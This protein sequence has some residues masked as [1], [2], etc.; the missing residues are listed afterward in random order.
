MTFG[1]IEAGGTKFVCATGSGPNDLKRVTRIPTTAPDETLTA[2]LDF[3]QAH[4]SPLRALGIGSFGPINPSVD[5]PAYGRLLNT[6]KAS[7]SNVDIIE[8]F[9]ALDCPVA[10]DTDVNAAAL[11]EYVWGAGTDVD[12]LLYLTIGT[13]I[14]GGFVVDGTPHHGLLHPEMG[15]L[16][17]RRL[18]ADTFDGLCP[19]HGDCLEGLASGPALEARVG[20]QPE[21]LPTDH[22]IWSIHAQYLAQACATLI[23][24]L[25]PER[26]ILG[27]GVMQQKHL[28]PRI[29]HH[30][31]QELAGYVDLPRLTSNL[32]SYIVPPHFGARAGVLGALHLAQRRAHEPHQHVRSHGHVSEHE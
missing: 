8:P 25:S 2:V 28:F 1:A 19:Y 23:Y 26:I 29:R 9:Q 24:V 5:S 30:L 27:G 4:S 12:S 22:P 16:R 6:P 3:F 7:W 32:D 15:H 10:V 17:V 21:K 31:R 18:E 11:A 14:G 20:T 13:G